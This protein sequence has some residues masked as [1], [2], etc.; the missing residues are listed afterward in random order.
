MVS[1]CALK[2]SAL[3]LNILTR[4]LKVRVINMEDASEHFKEVKKDVKKEHWE[5]A[6]KKSPD[7]FG[8]PSTVTGF[9]VAEAAPVVPCL[10]F[11]LQLEN[12]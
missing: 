1:T 4:F 3:A 2:M 8:V 5:K 12:I 11:S 10:D 7:Q 6:Y 9:L